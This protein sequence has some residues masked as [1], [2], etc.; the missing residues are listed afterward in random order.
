MK[1]NKNKTK[2]ST[3]PSEPSASPNN[4][5][6][7]EFKH[8]D[9]KEFLHEDIKQLKH[10][11]NKICK[12]EEK[13]F[14]S[15]EVIIAA[16]LKL[17]LLART[18]SDKTAAKNII[19][20]KEVA[21]TSTTTSTAETENTQLVDGRKVTVVDTPD[22]FS[23]GMSLEEF[24]HI[25]GPHAFL[26][27]IPVMN[28]EKTEHKE[29]KTQVSFFMMED[30]FGDRCWRNTIIIFSVT[31]EL[32]KNNIGEFIKSG[33]Q[34]LQELVAKCEKRFHCLNIKKRGDCSQ[35][36]ELL[37]KVETMVDRN[38]AKIYQIIEDMVMESALLKDVQHQMQE[39]LD[40][41]EELIKQYEED[42]TKLGTGQNSADNR[43]NIDALKKNCEIKK[44]VGEDIKGRYDRIVRMK[45]NREFIRVIL[46]ETMQTVWLSLSD[47]QNKNLDKKN[48]L[49]QLKESFSTNM[50]KF[51][52]IN[53][54]TDL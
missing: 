25:E 23:P 44:K 19:L 42:L 28:S 45:D 18:K 14:I 39:S 5:K 26:L 30:F 2:P 17:V 32:Q 40:K 3:Q 52:S 36:K 10:L 6:A 31:D 1:A 12:M 46:P 38:G 54:E 13:E 20:G 35:V 29:D 43:K 4:Q 41:N 16:E 15:N 27:I 21:A 48:E 11:K 37:E 51:P 47:E 7:P 8:S 24:R 33:D 50:E 9:D 53:V 34:E 49:S 22:L